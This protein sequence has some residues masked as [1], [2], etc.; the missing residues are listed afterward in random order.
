MSPQRHVNL[1]GRVGLLKA[2]YL[3]TTVSIREPQSQGASERRKAIIQAIKS[4]T[5]EQWLRLT[6]CRVVLRTFSNL[7]V[8]LL[9]CFGELT[10]VGFEFF[11]FQATSL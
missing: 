11:L 6:Y 5:S 4:L 7:S 2:T 1:I 3:R 10:K 8:P 9:H